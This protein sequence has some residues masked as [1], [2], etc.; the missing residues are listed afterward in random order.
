L[1]N[2]VNIEIERL[3]DQS[4]PALAYDGGSIRVPMDF[5]DQAVAKES[6]FL[7]YLHYFRTVFS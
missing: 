5:H 6:I 1:S 3:I 4:V 2:D 7:K